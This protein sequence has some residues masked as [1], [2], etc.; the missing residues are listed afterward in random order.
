[1]SAVDK[2][3][4]GILHPFLLAIGHDLDDLRH[5]HGGSLNFE[6]PIRARSNERFPV[7]ARLCHVFDWLLLTINSDDM[8]SRQR[9]GKAPPVTKPPKQVPSLQDMPSAGSSNQAHGKTSSMDTVRI[10]PRIPRQGA[11]DT[12]E[13]EH[14]LL[15]E[16]Q[17]QAA[18]GVSDDSSARAG[19]SR[20]PMSTRDKRSKGLL[21]VL[22]GFS[23]HYHGNVS[24]SR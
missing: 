6:L 7:R 21:C 5:G 14:A 11:H 3:Q 2:T 23:C 20:R 18:V 12:E 10:Q 8:S 16:E 22:C 9:K 19:R 17:S 1:V 4:L 24:N 13:I 15:E